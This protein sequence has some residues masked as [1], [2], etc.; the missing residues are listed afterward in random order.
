MY[1]SRDTTTVACWEF[2]H[3][4]SEWVSSDRAAVGPGGVLIAGR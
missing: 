3:R 4:A 1:N 2:L